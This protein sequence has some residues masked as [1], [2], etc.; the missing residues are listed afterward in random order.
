[1]M[2]YEA[3]QQL[4]Q[5]M[6]GLR[7]ADLNREWKWLYHDEGVRFALI[8][9][10]HELRALAVM[11]GEE[12]RHRPPAQHP[13]SQF[14]AAFRDLQAILIGV[15]PTL[16]DTR[17]APEEWPLR[18]ILGHMLFANRAFFNQIQYAL[19][20]AP[21]DPRESPPEFGRS[22]LGNDD[23]MEAFLSEADLPAIMDAFSALH[24]RILRDLGGLSAAQLATPT[25][26]WEEEDIPVSFRL[27]RFDAHLRQHTI[28]A[29]KT[30]AQLGHPPSEAQQWLRLVYQALAEAEGW[31]IDVP[32]PHP[33]ACAETADQ[34]AT[35]AREIS[36]LLS[37]D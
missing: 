13:L 2:L 14:H 33:A 10:Y 37:S 23:E 34:I 35:R 16:L 21:G 7:E 9:S 29:E 18:I 6:Q 28:Q 5:V 30:L 26:W 20:R 4:T 11:L 15:A 12:C 31:L 19:T 1:M 17:P 3:V 25:W 24:D 27:H 36:R 8:G 22:L 32:R